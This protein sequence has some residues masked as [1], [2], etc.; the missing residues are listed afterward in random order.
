MRS[1]GSSELA[2]LRTDPLQVVDEGPGDAVG[3]VVPLLAGLLL[4][5]RRGR[6]RDLTGQ[7]PLADERLE[8]WLDATTDETLGDSY[9]VTIQSDRGEPHSEVLRDSG[10]L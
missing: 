1:H 8:R 4:P 5:D 2:A 6:G 9:T 10:L 3:P 7:H